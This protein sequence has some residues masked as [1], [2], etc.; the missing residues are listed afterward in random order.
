MKKWSHISTS[1][2]T[3]FV[4]YPNEN[5]KIHSL[6]NCLFWLTLDDEV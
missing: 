2:L 3:Q 6:I 4:G 1:N 5:A